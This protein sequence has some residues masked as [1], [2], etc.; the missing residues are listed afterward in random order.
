MRSSRTTEHGLL[1]SVA[2]RLSLEKCGYR[3][4]DLSLKIAMI[5]ILRLAIPFKNNRGIDDEEAHSEYLLSRILL[6]TFAEL[7]FSFQVRERRVSVFK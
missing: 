1:T 6:M 4:T 3:V 2:V 5:L 7:N